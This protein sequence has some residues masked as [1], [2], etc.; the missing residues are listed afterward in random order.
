VY[1]SLGCMKWKLTHCRFTHCLLL[2]GASVDSDLGFSMLAHLVRE[3]DCQRRGSKWSF[4]QGHL[5]L[6]LNDLLTRLRADQYLDTLR[7]LLLLD[8]HGEGLVFLYD[9][10]IAL[11]R[12]GSMQSRPFGVCIEECRRGQRCNGARKLQ[13]VSVCRP[14]RTTFVTWDCVIHGPVQQI[15]TGALAGWWVTEDRHIAHW[16]SVVSPPGAIYF[17][18]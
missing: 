7:R 17:P 11:L 13:K 3:L 5:S 15:F 1:G 9:D 16:K 8:T 4:S 14:L 2:H 6:H 18:Q 12:P 10:Q